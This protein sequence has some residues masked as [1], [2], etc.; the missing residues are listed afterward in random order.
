M[1]LIVL[2]AIP[3]SLP[4]W[5]YQ[6]C[7]LLSWCDFAGTIICTG[8]PERIEYDD[9]DWTWRSYYE[10]HVIREEGTKACFFRHRAFALGN[11]FEP[12]EKVLRR[13]YPDAFAV[14]MLLHLLYVSPNLSADAIL[15]SL[16][17]NKN[18]IA[19]G[20]L[21]FCYNQLPNNY[22]SCLL[23]LSIFPQ[24]HIIRRTSLLRRWIA[25]GLVAERRTTKAKVKARCGIWTLDDE[26]ERIFDGLVTSGFLR[27]GTQ[28]LQARSGAAQCIT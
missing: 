2:D 10:F 16:D 17:C 11:K 19:K 22:K 7:H 24:D 28:A 25:E 5:K 8:R 23:Y 14:K 12:V 18:S 6:I 9:I 15:S 1:C 20:M 13:C 21:M 26:A 27:P 4:Y 3:D